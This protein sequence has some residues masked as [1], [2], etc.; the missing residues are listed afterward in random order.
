MGLS[1]AFDST[2]LSGCSE[3]S[4]NQFFLKFSVS[5]N[6]LKM[7][8]YIGFARLVYL[9]K[10]SLCQPNVFVSEADVYVHIAVGVGVKDDIVFFVGHVVFLRLSLEVVFDANLVYFSTMNNNALD[11]I[12]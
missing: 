5:K 11:N 3:I 1:F 8:T 6:M 7:L 10:L 2:M 4:N 9:N 12:P